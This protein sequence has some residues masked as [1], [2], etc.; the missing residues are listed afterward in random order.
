MPDGPSDLAPYFKTKRQGNLY[1]KIDI[2]TR[3]NKTIRIFI[4]ASD[5]TFKPG[6]I[7]NLGIPQ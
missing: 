7:P 2:H 3:I 4:C 6:N 1:L 5:E